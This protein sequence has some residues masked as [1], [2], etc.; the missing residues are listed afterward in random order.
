MYQHIASNSYYGNPGKGREISFHKHLYHTQAES[1]ILIG[2]DLFLTVEVYIK[3]LELGG[4]K[5][6]QELKWKIFL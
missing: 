5:K 4:R 1:F 2:K 6:T 3:A